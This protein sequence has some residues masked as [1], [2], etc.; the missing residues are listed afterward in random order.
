MA[1]MV[2][3]LDLFEEFSDNSLSDLKIFLLL[4]FR[5]Y[6]NALGPPNAI[7]PAPPIIISKFLSDAFKAVNT[8]SLSAACPSVTTINNAFFV[9][10][11]RELKIEQYK[12]V[13][14]F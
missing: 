2:N 5:I 12:C 1:S 4:L 14:S 9:I 6:E 11:L 10:F 13:S 3:L 7:D 8:S